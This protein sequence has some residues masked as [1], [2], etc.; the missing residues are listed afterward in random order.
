MV[1]L[2]PGV[3]FSF[4]LDSGCL[5][6]HN[7]HLYIVFESHYPS[8]PIEVKEMQMQ[9]PQ[10]LDPQSFEELNRHVLETMRTVSASAASTYVIHNG[11]VINEWYSGHHEHVEES[12]PVDA[13][14]RFNVASIRKTYLG[15]AVSLAL[16]ERKINSLNDPIGDYLD[17]LDENILDRT[18]IRHL[19]THTHGLQGS[20]KRIFPPGTGWKYNNSGVNL[21]VRLIR[22]VYGHSLAEVLENTVFAPCGFM[23]TGWT[24]E[25][26]DKLVWL[27]ETYAGNQGGEANLFVSTRELAFWGY[28]HLMKGMYD[29]RQML[30]APVFEQAVSIVTPAQLDDSLPRNGFF[31][32]VQDTPRHS[33]ELGTLLPEGSYQSL[34]LYGNALIVIPEYEAV[35]VR[36]LNQTGPNPPGFDY[37]RDIQ[38]FGNIVSSTIR[39]FA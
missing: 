1:Y 30:P 25:R 19:L 15:W 31:W 18:S 2:C 32:W 17:D 33:S 37:I 5:L 8:I 6:D 27:S 28:L 24:K 7:L 23:E 36:M 21:L 12:R 4:F 14:S 29:G 9:L 13:E 34:G 35:A 3:P 11:L 16:Y 22:K 39:R 26:S 20:N 10:C 38:Q